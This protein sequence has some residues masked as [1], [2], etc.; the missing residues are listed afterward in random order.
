[1]T[2]K[3]N[4]SFK[5]IIAQTYFL[6]RDYDNAIIWFEK[7]IDEHQDDLE[8]PACATILMANVYEFDNNQDK[9]KE[10]Y[11]QII[12]KYPHSSWVKAATKNLERLN[13]S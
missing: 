10:L 4:A 13:N 11:Y 6:K 1:M 3:L 7:I 8:W 9:A 12:K 2:P 5:S